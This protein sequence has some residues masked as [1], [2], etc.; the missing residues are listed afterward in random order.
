MKRKHASFTVIA[1]NYF[2]YGIVLADSMRASNPDNDFYIYFADGISSEVQRLLDLHDIIGID[3]TQTVDSKIFLK[4]ATY[5]EITE[6]CTAIKPFIIRQ[7]F[8]KEYSTVTYLDPDIYV[9]SSF[10]IHIHPKLESNSILITP[11]ICSPIQDS[12][13]PGEQVHLKTG[14]FNLGFISVKNDPIGNTFCTWWA[15]RC[16]TACFNDPFYGLFVDQKWINLVPGLFEKVYIDRNLG[17]N[18]A[19]W[20][21]H[22]REIANNKV[23]NEH[24]LVFFHF[25]GFV[26]ND[27]NSISKYQNRFTLSSRPD[28]KPLFEDYK[29]RVDDIFNSLPTMPGYK[30]GKLSNGVQISLV[31]RRFFYWNIEQLACPFESPGAEKSLLFAQKEMVFTTRNPTT[32]YPFLRTLTP[33]Q[34]PSTF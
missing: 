33:R 25:S 31:S 8:E 12:K 13:L 20:N 29:K 17:L 3:A 21:L 28:L 16:Q 4:M 2:G 34:S 30:Y 19:Y 27:I 5:Y 10:N 7:L 6:Y 26:S 14:T 23:N 9:Y 24:E 11:H 32:Q 18:V 15:N 22:E 1:Q